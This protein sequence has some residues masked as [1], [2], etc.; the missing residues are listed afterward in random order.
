M[1]KEFMY[2]LLVWI[3]KH[4]S[5]RLYEQL[6]L[7][8]GYFAIDTPYYKFLN[9]IPRPFD[10]MINNYF[11]GKLLSGAEVG[12]LRG[13]HSDSLLN[14]NKI[15]KLYL[16][17]TWNSKEELSYVGS[18]KDFDYL[19]DKYW[20]DDRVYLLRGKSKFIVKDFLNSELDFVYIDAEHTYSACKQDLDLW[21]KV[22][23]NNGLICGHDILK[24]DVFR[25]VLDFVNE[26]KYSLEIQIP[27]FIIYKNNSNG[28]NIRELNDMEIYNYFKKV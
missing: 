17:D 23:N 27:D 8:L 21:D 12:V 22:I 15:R 26:K 7:H 14:N 13:K 3:I 16:I 9:K 10:L 1:L 2:K 20:L 6:N 4:S 28:I 19:Q 25:A 24:P 18:E 11:N 5:K